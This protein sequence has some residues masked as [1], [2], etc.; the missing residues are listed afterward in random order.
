[1]NISFDEKAEE[2]YIKL[3]DYE[4][5][6]YEEILDSVTWD[7]DIN[8]K[9]VGVEVISLNKQQIDLYK[10]IEDIFT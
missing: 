7:Y 4:I 1:M 6:D 3:S 9:V 5:I 8:D 10:K 2:I